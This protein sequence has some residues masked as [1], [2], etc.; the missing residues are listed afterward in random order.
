MESLLQGFGGRFRHVE[1]EEILNA[2][3]R[4]RLKHPS[5]NNTCLEYTLL[6]VGIEVEV[7]EPGG[8]SKSVVERS[9]IT[10]FLTGHSQLIA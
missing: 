3:L 4:I 1:A 10:N 8:T 7:Q 2:D 5:F 9:N 6:V